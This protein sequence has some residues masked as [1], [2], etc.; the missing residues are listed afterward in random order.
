MQ[1]DVLFYVLSSDSPEARMQFLGKLLN[2]I[3]S[4]KR[5]CDVRFV[6]LNEAQR[7]DTQLWNYRPSSF[8][9]HALANEFKA[10]IQFYDSNISATCDDVLI[11]MHP[12]FYDN[13]TGYQRTIE[14]LD[15]SQHLIEKGRERWRQYKQLGFE[16]TVHK[17]P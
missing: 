17:I 5:K 12:D 11:N 14:V 15:Q 3:W 10:P 13:F 9:P 8:I 2:K 7:M 6:D 1:Q 4:E 16:P